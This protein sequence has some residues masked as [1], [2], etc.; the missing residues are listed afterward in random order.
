MTA[1]KPREDA[2]NAEPSFEHGFVWESGEALDLAEV[3][4]AAFDYRGNVTIGLDGGETIAG[5]LYNRTANGAQASIDLF[6]VDGGQRRILYTA[7]KR[8]EFSGKDTAAGK[9][10]ETWLAKYN[11]KKAAEE[12]GEEVDSIDLFPEELD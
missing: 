8:L 10:W 2:A 12:R 6:P 11:A 7:I 3:I 4:E 1:E 9:S 5:Y